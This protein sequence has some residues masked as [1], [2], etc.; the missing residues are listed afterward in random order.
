VCAAAASVCAAATTT[1]ARGPCR[2]PIATVPAMDHDGYCL[3]ESHAIMCYL[4]D[5]FDWPLYPKDLKVGY[6]IVK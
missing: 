4:G 6:K 2:F 3:S 5:A 1:A